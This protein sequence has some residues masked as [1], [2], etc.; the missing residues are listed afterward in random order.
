[1]RVCKARQLEGQLT[2]SD[3]PSDVDI[4]PPA[5]EPEGSK[6]RMY[7]R[8]FA[9]LRVVL[10][11]IMREMS[12]RYVQTPGGYIWAV[13]EPVGFIALLAVGFSLMGRVPPLGN[14]F[15]LFYA[16]GFLP[17]NLYRSM[18]SDVSSAIKFSRSLLLYPAV[19]WLDAI[20]ARFV[21]GTI[22][23][24]LVI[25]FVLGGTVIITGYTPTFNMVPIIE[26][27]VAAVLLGL[28]IGTL[29]AILFYWAPLWQT[30]WKIINRPLFL[31]SGVIFL[32]DDLPTHLQKLFWWNPLVH[33]NELMRSGIYPS[34]QPHFI[35]MPYVLG[36]ALVCF[37]MGQ[38][39]LRAHSRDLI[40][41]E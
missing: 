15:V 33:I 27:I 5:L 14:S 24:V 34:Y 25:F 35:S 18:E 23:G 7:R 36:I 31:L 40:S 9:T 22:T 21:L 17:F 38:L 3:P 16:S 28:G 39:F 11:L 4:I 10:A 26:S 2:V 29:N 6:S 1:M 12:T 37:M 32:F 13:L 20:L 30:A 41:K 8:R 19:T